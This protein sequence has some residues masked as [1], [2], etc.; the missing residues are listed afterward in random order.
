M[1]GRRRP[2]KP[3]PRVLMACGH[4]AD[5]R[6]KHGQPCC[7]RCL[8]LDPLA[9]QVVESQAATTPKGDTP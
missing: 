4:I 7:S 6:L 9:V 2:N 3:R 1:S 5:A 8:G